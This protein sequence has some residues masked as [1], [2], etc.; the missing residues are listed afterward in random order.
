MFY[1]S[2]IQIKDLTSN[3]V[4]ISICNSMNKMLNLPVLT[5]STKQ[6]NKNIK[7]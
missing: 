4:F 3:H 7:N 6:K 1:R 5:Y 2:N